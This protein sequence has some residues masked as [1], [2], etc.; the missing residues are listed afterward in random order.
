MTKVSSKDYEKAVRDYAFGSGT[1]K[2]VQRVDPMRRQIEDTAKS[3][4]A[5][6][7]GQYRTVAPKKQK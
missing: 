7:S 5:R 4:A 2:D 3:H 1:L 6:H